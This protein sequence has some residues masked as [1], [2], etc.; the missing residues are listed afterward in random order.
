[1]INTA[2]ELNESFS[3]D[4][5]LKLGIL[6]TENNIVEV[7]NHSRYISPVPAI[8]D[9]GLDKVIRRIDRLTSGLRYLRYSKIA[10]NENIRK[11]NG[12]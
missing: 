2:S 11:H 7:Y 3:V 12:Y 4:S 10:K 8:S 9:E 5:S 1:M 6:H